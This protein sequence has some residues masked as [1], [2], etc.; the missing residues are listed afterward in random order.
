VLGT[1]HELHDRSA[2]QWGRIEDAIRSLEAQNERAAAELR[3]E[4]ARRGGRAPRHPP[5]ETPPT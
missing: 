3:D 2:E 1:V 4:L 5:A